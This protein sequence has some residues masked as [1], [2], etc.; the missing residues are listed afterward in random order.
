MPKKEEAED[1]I[2]A[3]ERAIVGGRS[4]FCKSCEAENRIR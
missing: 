4:L 3:F 2:K 1:A